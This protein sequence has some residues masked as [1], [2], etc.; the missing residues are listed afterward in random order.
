MEPEMETP[1]RHYTPEQKVN[2][3]R[4]H[5]LLTALFWK[6]SGMASL[7]AVFLLFCA[8]IALIPITVHLYKTRK[9]SIIHK[10]TFQAAIAYFPL[11]VL[12][13]G[14]AYRLP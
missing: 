6:W 3:L 4:Q 8:P 9:A 5:L 11:I 14:A 1:R 10:R 13:F 2:I 12:S 7:G